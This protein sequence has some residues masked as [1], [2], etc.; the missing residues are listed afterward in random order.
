MAGP[1]EQNLREGTAYLNANLERI[2]AGEDV[3]VGEYF[4]EDTVLINFEPSP[5][6]GTYRGHEGLARWTHDIFDEFTEGRIELLEVR[7][8]GDLAAA[9]MQLSGRGRAS[10]IQGSFEWGALFTMRDGLCARA[11]SHPTFEQTLQIFEERRAG[12]D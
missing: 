7:E 4:T 8:E 6:P 3:P 5:F 9:R 12:A 2:L 1:N 11:E 10:G